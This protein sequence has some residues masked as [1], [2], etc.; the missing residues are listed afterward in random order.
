MQHKGD[1]Q[2]IINLKKFV[3]ACLHIK[4]QKPF[5]GTPTE[6]RPADTRVSL[7]FCVP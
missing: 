7:S 1:G 6:R 2:F 5:A 3:N 4:E